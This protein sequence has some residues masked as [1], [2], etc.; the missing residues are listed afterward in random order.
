MLSISDA[1]FIIVD[2]ETTGSD[3]QKNR[4]TDIACIT[5]NNFEIVDTY[6]SLVN[7]YQSIPWYIQRMTG[8]DYKMSKNAPEPI[9]VFR[10]I[11]ELLQQKNTFFVAHNVNFDY[12]F[13]KE[14]IKRLHIPFVDIPILCSL[15]LARKVLPSNI[16]KNV[17]A[18]A[19]YFNIPIINRHRAFDDA[20]ATAI[21]FI[22]TLH[23]IRDRYGINDV[24][25]L[26][27]F[28]DSKTK[29]ATKITQRL[30]EKLLPY[31]NIVPNQS[32][33]LMF[34]D[35]KGD[36]LHI[37]KTNNLKEHLN[38]FIEQCLNSVKNVKNILKHFYRLEWIETNNELETIITEYRKIRQFTPQFNFLYRI[39]LTNANDIKIN[40][41]TQKQL[42]KNF[43]MIVLLE[44]SEQ[45]RIVDIYFIKHGIYQT[46]YSIGCKANLKSLFDA[47][48]NIY[49]SDKLDTEVDIDEMKFISNW[50]SKND[51]ISKTIKISDETDESN[52]YQKIEHT[53]RKFYSV[54]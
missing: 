44:N 4:V 20:L 28:Q 43:S 37:T 27:D 53:I 9:F 54:S 21:F 6:C 33:V 34:I 42:S 25:E 3:S 31:T 17:S 35:K 5:V 29:Q 7:P 23:I 22:E 19:E 41:H 32:G 47:I 30:G 14:S 46:S 12:G 38:Y 51:G 16:K 26:L 10:K 8:I 39:D 52:L 13:V 50:L 45:E 24:Y 1:N 15:K 36:V 40:E 49:F 18:I 2:V 48:G 11:A